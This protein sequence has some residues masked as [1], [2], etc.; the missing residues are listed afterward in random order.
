MA[1]RFEQ[2]LLDEIFNAA[3][4]FAFRLI[5]RFQRAG[6]MAA[7]MA[8]LRAVG[9][10]LGE[11]AWALWDDFRPKADIRFGYCAVRKLLPVNRISKIYLNPWLPAPIAESVIATLRE[12]PDCKRLLISKSH[13]IDSGRWKKA[14]DKVI[15]RKQPSKIKLTKSK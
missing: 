9:Y 4:P 3:A 6:L 8:R 12:L 5:L 14:G 10:L 13:L 15:G 2:S 1:V 11:M 7:S